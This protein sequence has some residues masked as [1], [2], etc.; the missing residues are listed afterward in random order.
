MLGREKRDWDAFRRVMSL[1]SKYANRSDGAVTTVNP[2]EFVLE[3][4]YSKSHSSD[5]T[6]PRVLKKI[7][8]WT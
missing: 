7:S 4:K 6:D 1:A 5:K 8:L 3:F 2:M